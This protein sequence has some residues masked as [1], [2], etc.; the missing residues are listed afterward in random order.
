LLRQ[1]GDGFTFGASM[2]DGLPS[3][4]PSRLRASRPGK[5]SA[6]DYIV[7]ELG[8]MNR[9][10]TDLPAGGRV[11]GSGKGAAEGRSSEKRAE[12]AGG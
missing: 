5:R 8:T 6:T 11:N 1:A 7:V 3:R 4:L 10:P 12:F 9:A 2:R